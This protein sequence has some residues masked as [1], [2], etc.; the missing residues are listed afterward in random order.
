[1]GFKNI[2]N[3]DLKKF[4]FEKIIAD[5]NKNTNFVTLKQLIRKEDN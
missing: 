5:I 2:S 1:M 4:V 3:Y